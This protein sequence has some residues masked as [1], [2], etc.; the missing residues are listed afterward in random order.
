MALKFIDIN[1]LT[2]S[3][4]HNGNMGHNSGLDA[5]LL[6]GKQAVDFARRY[7]FSGEEESVDLDNL[8]ES[9][10]YHATDYA[11]ETTT[12]KNTPVSVG[13]GGFGL[14]VVRVGGFYCYQIYKP[15]GCTYDMYMRSRYYPDS[16]AWTAWSKMWNSGNDGSGS[17]LDADKVRNTTPGT[18]GLQYLAAA[19]VS[20]IAALILADLKTVDG[21]GSG[22]ET[23]KI[24]F[25]TKTGTSTG[26]QGQAS[27]DENYLYLCTATDV[28]KRV[29]LTS[30]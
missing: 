3:V 6:D 2:R 24:P 28:W 18:R 13:I 1:G 20:N 17:G 5:D 12:F 27:F 22:L 16:M 11:H 23:D 25:G 14:S 30:F 21:A 9:G 29:A 15:Y 10:F 26:T 19:A 8:I 7:V 4:W